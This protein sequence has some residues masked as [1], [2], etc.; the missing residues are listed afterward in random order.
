MKKFRLFAV[1]MAVVLTFACASAET[2]PAIEYDL[3][4]LEDFTELSSCMFSD[5]ET[6]VEEYGLMLMNETDGFKVYANEHMMLVGSDIVESIILIGGEYT[7]YG[8]APGMPIEEASEQIAAAG[9]DKLDFKSLSGSVEFMRY[10]SEDSPVN[11]DGYDSY[12]TVMPENG[13]V[14]EIMWLSYTFVEMAEMAGF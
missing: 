6:C 4:G 11:Y 3:S 1:L 10:A 8:A 5:T 14:T 9:L 12:I 2:V 13:V 7:I